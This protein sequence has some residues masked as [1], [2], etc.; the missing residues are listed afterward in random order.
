MTEARNQAERYARALPVEHGYPPFILVLD[1]GNVLE[2]FADFSG[3]GKNYA[4]FPDRQSYRITMDDLLDP[5]I[6]DRL[7]A[8]WQDPLSLDPA[9]K[10]AEVTNDISERLARIVLH[11]LQGPIEVAGKMWNSAMPGHKDYAGFDDRV[12][13][14]LLTYQRRAWGHSGRAIDPDFI[15]DARAQT[16]NGTT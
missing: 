11:G 14:G 9:R 3:Q 8:I 5:N 7:R 1:I 6:Q 4:H 2:V 15:A 16:A 13:S 12:A 10:S